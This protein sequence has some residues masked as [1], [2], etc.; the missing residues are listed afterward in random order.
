MNLEVTSTFIT[1]LVEFYQRRIHFELYQV[2]VYIHVCIH[3]AYRTFEWVT[4]FQICAIFS[5]RLH[6]FWK[7]TFCVFNDYVLCMC[8]YSKKYRRQC[9]HTVFQLAS[10]MLTTFIEM[11]NNSFVFRSLRGAISPNTPSNWRWRRCLLCL[12]VSFSSVSILSRSLM[13]MSHLKSV[14]SVQIHGTFLVSKQ[15]NFQEMK[16]L[17]DLYFTY[18]GHSL[19]HTHACT[20]LVLKP[21]SLSCV[22]VQFDSTYCVNR[23]SCR[24][25]K[26][27][28]I[29]YL[30]HPHEVSFLS[31]KTFQNFK[32]NTN[33]TLLLNQ[34]C[35]LMH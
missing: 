23:K 32:Q 28:K 33:I 34:M 10:E 8:T 30:D 27:L 4:S 29:I 26:K 2:H 21:E 1:P 22:T 11:Q 18:Y 6:L 12:S 5:Y 17:L 35:W 19:T 9:I 14:R 16:R 24:E 13:M 15:S 31:P 25:S 7:W 20:Q 3:S